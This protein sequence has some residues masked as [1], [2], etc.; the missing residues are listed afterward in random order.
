ML[1]TLVEGGRGGMR[2][3]ILRVQKLFQQLNEKENY[4]KEKDIYLN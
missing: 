1:P 4:K 2:L 3:V